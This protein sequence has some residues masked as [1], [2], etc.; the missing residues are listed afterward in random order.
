MVY[1]IRADRPFQ[2]I[3]AQT[4]EALER[5]GFEVRCTFRLAPIRG[6]GGG[7]ALG[8]SVFLLYESG[9][10]S[11]PLGRVTL[12]ERGRDVVLATLPASQ[13]QD[14]EADL[15]VALS[16]GDLDFC[17]SSS[18]GGARADALIGP[19]NPKRDRNS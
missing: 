12:Q 17:V 5:R 19:E 3:E 9:A 6:N 1:V 10:P 13:T 16:L 7:E 8:Y 11:R 14:F 18:N 2:Q 15:V 4:I